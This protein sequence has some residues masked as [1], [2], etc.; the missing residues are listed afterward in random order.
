MM[1]L[2]ITVKNRGIPQLKKKYL[3]V[4]IAKALGHIAF[5]WWK[6][7]RPIHFTGAGARKYRYTRR[8][9]KDVFTETIKRKKKGKPR[10][11]SGKP[12]VWSGRSF[13]LSKQKRIKSTSKRSSVTMPVRAF[14]RRPPRNKQLR[15]NEEFARILA[16]ETKSLE[17]QGSADLQK[18][19]LKYGIKSSVTIRS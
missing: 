1:P 8:A 13:E 14:N 15:M 11:P 12:L 2:I 10:S 19:L 4:L 6:D 5:L 7:I 16:S 3:N 17:K 18:R 9:T